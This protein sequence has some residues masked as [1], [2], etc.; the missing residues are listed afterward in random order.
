MALQHAR[1][2]LSGS[3]ARTMST[4]AAGENKLTLPELPYEYS[5]LEPYISAE[6]MELHHSKHHQ[7]YVN[8][9]NAALEQWAEADAKK[10][11]SAAPR[12][13]SALHFNGGGHLN[14]SIFWQNLCPAK[15]AAPLEG[16]LLDAIK[17]DF[18]SLEEMQS[19]M[20]AASAGIQ[21]SGWGWLAA[22]PVTGK[23]YIVT[24]P[25]QDTTRRA[26]RNPAA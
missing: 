10:E 8:N 21:G 17:R 23:L 26:S 2:L 20:K 19:K 25:N 22:K 1:K 5:A 11:S 4:F 14:H 16:P 13:S 3:C 18:G 15:D 7:T 12:I 24:S 6:I 9:Y